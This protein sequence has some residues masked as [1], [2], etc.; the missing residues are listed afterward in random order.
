[1]A[2]ERAERARARRRSVIERQGTEAARSVR[3]LMKA[4]HELLLLI[5]LRT[6]RVLEVSMLMQQM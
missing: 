6:Q 3:L 1:M 4:A 5:F 2:Q